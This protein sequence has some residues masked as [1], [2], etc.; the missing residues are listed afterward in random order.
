MTQRKYIIAWIV[1][2][3][4]LIPSLTA[5]AEMLECTPT[6]KR[7]MSSFSNAEST[8][9]TTQSAHDKRVPTVWGFTAS[10]Y[11][12]GF[13][14]RRMANGQRFNMYSLVVA[15]RSLPIEMCLD[16]TNPEN[17]RS[18][19]VIVKDRGPYIRGRNLDVSYRVARELGFVDEGVTEL[20][21]KPCI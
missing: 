3:V 9:E 14:G 16:L 18:V 17:G 4:L 5:S 15:H 19:Q 20:Q 8:T 21:G 7:P 2:F 1:F 10:W 11:G 6:P 13:H 12:P